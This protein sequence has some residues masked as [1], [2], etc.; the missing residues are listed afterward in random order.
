[1]LPSHLRRHPAAAPVQRALALALTIALLGTGSGCSYAFSRGPPPRLDAD[2]D[3][4]AA[5]PPG[6]CTTSS[7]PASLDTLAAIP[8]LGAGVLGVVG[9]AGNQGYAKEFIVPS[10]LLLA[11]GTTFA[12]SAVTGFGR[13]R[14]CRRVQQLQPTEP[15]V[16]KQAA[17]ESTS[18]ASP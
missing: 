16:V 4:R 11:L 7:A 8:F 5:P 1:M 6:R 12:A 9:G 17:R 15:G 2:H 18:T 3:D 10:I 13:V 14:D